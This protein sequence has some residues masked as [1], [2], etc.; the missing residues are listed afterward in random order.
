[1]SE[2]ET[3]VLKRENSESENIS[4]WIWVFLILSFCFGGW[5]SFENPRINELEKKVARI[6]GQISMIGGKSL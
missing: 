4:E 3:E 1:M 6:E 5:G 2:Q